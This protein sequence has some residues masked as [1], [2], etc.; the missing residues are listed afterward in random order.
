[1]PPPKYIVK[2]QNSMRK[3]RPGRSL[4]DSEYAAVSVKNRLMSVPATV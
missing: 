3:R 4:F 1:M 2:V